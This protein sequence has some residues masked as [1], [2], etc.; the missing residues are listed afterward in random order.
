MRRTYPRVD[1]GLVL[2]RGAQDRRPDQRDRAD[3]SGDRRRDG[4][5]RT[6]DGDGEIM[7]QAAETPAAR[8]DASPPVEDAEK[9][10]ARASDSTG[11]P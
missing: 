4:L 2:A 8:R 7:E 11:K 3:A 5:G 6:A 9:T 10:I 1:T